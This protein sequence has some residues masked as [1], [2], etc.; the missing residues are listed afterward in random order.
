MALCAKLTVTILR[1]V[2]IALTLAVLLYCQSVFDGKPNSD[3]EEVFIMLMFILSVPA[4]FVAGP[5]AVAFGFERVL[6]AAFTYRSPG[7]EIPIASLSCPL[8]REFVA[9]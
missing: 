7:N 8:V 4:S 1:S 3:S 6:H 5:I 2:W 9:G